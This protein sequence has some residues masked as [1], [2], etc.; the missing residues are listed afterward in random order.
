MSPVLATHWSLKSICIHNVCHALATHW[1]LASICVYNISPALAT[2][3]GLKLLCIHNTSLALATLNLARFFN[4]L[5][6]LPVYEDKRVQNIK[7]AM[8]SRLQKKRE[9]ARLRVARHR[10]KQRNTSKKLK[11]VLEYLHDKYPQIRLEV[12]SIVDS[13][14]GQAIAETSQTQEPSEVCG[15]AHQDVFAV[16]PVLDPKGGPVRVQIVFPHHNLVPTVTN[17]EPKRQ[18]LMD[19]PR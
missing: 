19:S 12:Q 11:S 1:G 2:H 17:N 18:V 13:I 15:Q 8:E 5:S 10:E 16:L 6:V 7:A 3:W 14:D 9:Q 4:Q